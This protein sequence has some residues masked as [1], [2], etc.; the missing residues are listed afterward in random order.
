MAK[1]HSRVEEHF[2]CIYH[3]GKGRVGPE[4]Q[5]H[6]DLNLSSATYCVTRFI[7][8]YVSKSHI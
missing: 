3:M 6:L 8:Q 7:A 4:N 1:K 2:F 5:I